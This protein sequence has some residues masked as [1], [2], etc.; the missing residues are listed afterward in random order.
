MVS[1]LLL[2]GIAGA[3]EV[4]LSL[5]G[6]SEYDSNVFRTPDEEQDDVIFRL[7]PTIS[8]VEDREKLNYSATYSFPYEIGVK[9]S[10]DVSD[11]NH[12][13]NATVNYRATPQTELFAN[14]GVFY[15]EGLFRQNTNFE[16]NPPGDLNDERSR[17]FDDTLALGVTHRF[18][19]RLSSTFVTRGEAFETSQ[20][21]R[22]DNVSF[23]S[24]LS[25]QYMLTEQ[26]E[27]GGGFAFSRQMFER[28]T[29]RPSSDTNYYN[30][31]GSWQWMF[32][33][34]TTFYVQ[35]GPALVQTDQSGGSVVPGGPIQTTPFNF[36][37]DNGLPA[38]QVGNFADCPMQN[39]SSYALVGVGCRPAVVHNDP[40]NPAE[41]AAYLD[42][43]DD[44]VTVLTPLALTG[45]SDLRLT[46]FANASITKR[47]TPTL[48][49]SLSYV[50]Q[51]N[52]ASGID[53]AAVIDAVTL[54]NT[55][56]I[57]E[58]WDAGVRA[59]WTLR[60]SATQG[61]RAGLTVVAKDLGPGVSF[62]AA[63]IS[64]PGALTEV[65]SS[66]S[67]D[68]QR[69]GMA[70]RIAYRLTKNTVT[71]LQY[72]YNKQSSNGNSVGSPSDFDDHLLT[73]TVQYNFE[74]IGL[75]W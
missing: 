3:A 24:T 43:I 71:A 67:L 26:H 27:V 25:T 35:A 48:A 63:Q 74:P 54:S 50:R 2:P 55:W 52:T 5:A 34:T 75:P 44:G 62:D 37:T 40:S 13:A 36:I 45:V 32:D 69:W 8:L 9:Y 23:G 14:N 60:T 49:S 38:V 46:Y 66:D 4:R 73:F 42:I 19:P 16:D 30:L 57:S 65:T 47:W 70:A 6:S 68:T 20:D 7:T 51:E 21:D 64:G 41:Q 31:F 12:F 28:I 72:S 61:A 18:T 59:D 56:R 1:A 53:G 33:E 29:G 58:R 22:S 10:N 15:S 39:G 17:V 11:F